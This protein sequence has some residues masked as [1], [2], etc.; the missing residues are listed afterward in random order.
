[1]RGSLLP[2]ALS[3]VQS[4]AWS[5]GFSARLSRWTGRGGFLLAVLKSFR[6]RLGSGLLGSWAFAVVLTLALLGSGFEEV[7]E[8]RGKVRRAQ[9]VLEHVDL[10]AE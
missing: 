7:L 4:V 6:A 2:A 3:G 9:E 8:F 1:M 5:A 10:G